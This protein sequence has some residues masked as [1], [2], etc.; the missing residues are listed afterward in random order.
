MV[1]AGVSRF[2]HS[3]SQHFKQLFQDLKYLSDFCARV[4]ALKVSLGLKQLLLLPYIS[5]GE[6]LG[7]EQATAAL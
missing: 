5:A 3:S 2:E 7:Y 1:E 4:T 6:Q